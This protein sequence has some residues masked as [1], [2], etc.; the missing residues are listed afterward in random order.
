[1]I[2]FCRIDDSVLVYV[3]L[4]LSGKGVNWL[5]FSRKVMIF[6]NV[7]PEAR[8]NFSAALISVISFSVLCKFTL[9][10]MFGVSW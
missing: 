7:K 4:S 8:I 5:S 2:V 1:M 3:V 10:L 6:S 9:I